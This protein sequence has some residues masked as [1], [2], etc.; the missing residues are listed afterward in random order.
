[1]QK[2]VDSMELSDW[3]EGPF[4]YRLSLIHNFETDI[5]YRRAKEQ[6]EKGK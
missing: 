4:L 3:E 1:M 6:A 5:A 2:R